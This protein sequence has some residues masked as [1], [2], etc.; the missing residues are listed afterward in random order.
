[1]KHVS[2]HQIGDANSHCKL[3]IYYIVIIILGFVTIST[4]IHTQLNPNKMDNNVVVTQNTLISKTVNIENASLHLNAHT[5]VM[6]KN[7]THNKSALN[8]I[9]LTQQDGIGTNSRT[10]PTTGNENPTKMP[11]NTLCWQ[12]SS[13]RGTWKSENTWHHTSCGDV[14]LSA[15]EEYTLISKLGMSRNLFIGDSTMSRLFQTFMRPQYDVRQKTAGR[16]D[17]CP[18][19]GMAKNRFPRKTP[20]V[21]EVEGPFVFGLQNPGCSDCFGCNNRLISRTQTGRMNSSWEYLGIEFARDTELQCSYDNKQSTSTQ[22]TASDY[23][24]NKTYTHIFFNTGIHDKLLCNIRHISNQTCILKY[25]LNIWNYAHK[26]KLAV[27]SKLTRL[28]F[29]TTSYQKTQSQDEYTQSLNAAAVRVMKNLHIEVIDIS[30]LST[31]TSRISAFK[32]IRTDEYHMIPAYYN[33]VK[34]VLL[35]QL[36]S[37]SSLHTPAL[38]R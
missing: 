20:V 4:F 28:V 27:D 19:Y 21:S 31:K 17:N 36:I 16:C 38:P 2:A 18:Y 10:V 33:V 25:E 22:E 3:Y 29:I 1:M 6:Q 7:T 37:H 23:I 13:L 8:G 14:L 34:Y 5:L 30:K 15:I 35:M 12:K 24:R 11:K 26:L 32:K 9:I